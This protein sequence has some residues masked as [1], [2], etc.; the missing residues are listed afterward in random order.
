MDSIL[1]GLAILLI[2]L[3]G[4][5]TQMA[6]REL[7]KRVDR[8][9]EDLVNFGALVMDVNNSLDSLL[10]DVDESKA[11]TYGDSPKSSK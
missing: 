7:S 10:R 5:F 6:L 3:G 9:Q 8:L 11:R 1:T 4:F 2:A